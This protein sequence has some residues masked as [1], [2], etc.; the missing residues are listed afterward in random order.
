MLHYH[1]FSQIIINC[2]FFSGAEHLNVS[3]GLAGEHIILKIGNGTP[4]HAKLLSENLSA[5]MHNNITDKPNANTI[6]QHG[7]YQLVEEPWILESI[8]ASKKPVAR[9]KNKKGKKKFVNNKHDSSR[10]SEYMPREDQPVEEPWLFE[11]MVEAHE[12]VVHAD[13]KIEAKDIIRKLIEKPPAPLEE[14]KPTTGEPSSRVILINSSVC[15]MQRIAVLEDGKLVELLLEP[16]KN[17]VQ[18]DSIYLGIVTK[19]VPHMG[20]AF[21]DIGISRPSLMGIKQNRDPFV[22]P[23]VVKISR[24]DPVD[25]SYYNE[26][27]LPTYDEDDDMSDDEFA[28]EETHDG[29]SSFPV[30]NITDNEEGIA[31]IPD[32]KIDIVDSAEFEGIS[33]YDED[34]EDENGHME[35][36]YSEEILQAD[37][38]EISNDLKT[39]SSIQHALRESNDDTNGSRWSQVRKGTKIMVQVVKE[40]LGTKGPTLS[41]FPCLR[42]R[43]WVRSWGF[44]HN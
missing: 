16:I 8:V 10:A 39:L 34:K 36:E 14:N 42:S 19:L 41:P 11:S 27:Y 24:A 32:S 1:I 3:S 22:Y 40:G 33:G 43:F 12:T 29:S 7:G 31:L 15:T 30:E 6:S 37:Q 35:D 23:Q 5:S 21:V 9:V 20:G 26:E 25:D 44:L 38:S 17:N 4:L 28:D 2:G 13:G 18:C